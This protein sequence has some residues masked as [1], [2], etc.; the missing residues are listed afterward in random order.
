MS[1]NI[2]EIKESISIPE[3]LR[4]LGH[5]CPDKEDCMIKSPVRDE[6]TA[7]FHVFDRGRKGKD[8][9]GSFS[10][11]VIDLYKEI[12]GTDDS[13]D[14]IKAVAEM[15]GVVEQEHERL[16]APFM[17]KRKRVIEVDHEEW[18]DEWRKFAL[19]ACGNML[20][21]SSEGLNRLMIKKG[22]N[23]DV[24][25]ELARKGHLGLDDDGKMLYIYPH[26]IKKRWD[27]DSSRGDRWLWGKAKDN[28]WRANG[29]MDIEKKSLFLTEGETDLISLL[30]Y[31]P[32]AENELV[33]SVP[34][35]FW[36]PGPVMAYQIGS[37]R[38]I[39]LM[40]D[41]DNAGFEATENVA[42]A[43]KSHATNC[44]V[45]ALSWKKILAELKPKKKKPD[46]GEVIGQLK[47]KIDC[48]FIIV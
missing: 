37:H 39:Y 27:A 9:G 6:R 42:T 25:W 7:S 26:G 1:Y 10:G 15:A 29:I 21:V 19:K 16:H 30:R 41:C 12:T 38:E 43:F 45:H 35:A 17:P 48:Y 13:F 5:E 46:L 4:H 11:D 28:L 2:E 18:T 32:E 24:V 44:T 47:E 14:A 40:F 31:R 3:M 36:T 22:W 8:F 20:S 23:F 34:G 33:C